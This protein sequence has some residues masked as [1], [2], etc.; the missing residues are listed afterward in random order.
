M[1]ANNGNIQTG[2]FPLPPNPSE[3]VRITQIKYAKSVNPKPP[4]TV[5]LR[6][7]LLAI[8]PPN[9]KP[10]TLPT[11]PIIVKIDVVACPDVVL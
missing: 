11:P 10:I 6:P 5:Y 4:T 8:N 1:N 9:A 3:N 2:T 7:I